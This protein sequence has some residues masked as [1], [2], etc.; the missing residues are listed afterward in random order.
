MIKV[1][2]L[3]LAC[4]TFSATA[5]LVFSGRTV[6]SSQFQVD[7]PFG[8]AVKTT[9]DPANIWSWHHSFQASGTVDVLVDINGN[10]VMDTENPFVRVIV[11]DLEIVGTQNSSP[12]TAWIRDGVGRRYAVGHGQGQGTAP[13]HHVALSTPIVLPV[14]S[15]LSVELQAGSPCEVNLVGRVVNL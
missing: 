9:V 8:S 13:V 1:G 7:V 10:S 11:T 4:S 2:L 5:V 3:V 6:Y 14:G 15:P 12:S